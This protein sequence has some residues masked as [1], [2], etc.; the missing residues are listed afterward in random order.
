MSGSSFLRDGRGNAGAEMALMLP[1][2]LLLLFVGLEAGH[3]IWTQ[4]KLTEAVRN[5]ARYASRL[6][7]VQ[8]CPEFDAG[9]LARI[10]LL[11][12]TG[13]LSDSAAK[14]LVP[15]WTED[16]VTISRFCGAFV[17]TGIYSD[18][19]GE[20]APLVSVQAKDVPYS[21]LFGVLGVIDPDIKLNARSNAAVIGL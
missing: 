16:Q 2:L 5:G 14:A 4:H 1:L 13:Q 9:A 8:V 10:K 18:L 21:S 11:T 3:F 6:D 20:K 17:E 7:V 12:R 15:G 19:H